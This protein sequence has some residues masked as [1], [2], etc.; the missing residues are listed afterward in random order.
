VQGGG[1]FF[2]VIGQQTYASAGIYNVNVEL[3]PFPLFSH[4]FEDAS[5]AIVGGACRSDE[6]TKL[7]W[8]FSTAKGANPW[9]SGVPAGCGHPSVSITQP[10]GTS[11]IV[12]AGSQLKIEYQVKPIPAPSDDVIVSVFDAAATFQLSCGGGAVA[13]PSTVTVNADGSTYPDIGVAS[14]SWYPPPNAPFLVGRYDSY[15]G[16][17]V[18]PDACGGGGPTFSAT[19]SIY[20][21]TAAP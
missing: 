11:T 17:A 15:Q 4:E 10:T 18:I 12:P 13:D 21:P 1:G 7:R 8:R 3:S 14:Y 2:S 16:T 20:P 19:V 9:S 6:T 5:T